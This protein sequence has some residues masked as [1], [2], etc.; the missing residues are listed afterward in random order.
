MLAGQ[1]SQRI[2]FSGHKSDL[3]KAI[4]HFTE[5]V[6]LSS[7]Q[8]IVFALFYLAALLLTRF[9]YYEQPDDIKSSIK[10]FRFLRINFHSVEAFEVPD[11]SGD[12]STHLFGALALG[13]VLTPGEMAQDLDEMVAL[14]PEVITADILTYHRKSAIQDFSRAVANL[15]TEIFRREDTH[16]VADRAIH[17]LREATVLNPDLEIAYALAACLAFRF[18]TTFV[19]KDYEEAI[20][21]FDRIISTCSPGTNLTVMEINVI[22]LILGLLVSRENLSPTPESLEHGIHRLRTLVPYSLGDEDRTRLNLTLN[23]FTHKRF[24]YFGLSGNSGG[25]PPGPYSDLQP[26]T[27]FGRQSESETGSQ[28]QETMYCLNDVATAIM[29]DETTDVGVA[30]EESRKLIPLW[31]SS[32]RWSPSSDLVHM[33][34]GILLNAYRRTERLDYLNEAIITCRDLHKISAAPKLIHFWVGSALHNSLKTR[35]ELLLLPQDLE[36]L[37][38]LSSELAK[39]SSGEVFTRFEISCFWATEARVRVHPSASIAYEMAMSLLQETLVFCPTLQTQHHRLVD[40]SRKGGRFPSDYPSYRIVN[41]EVEE[42]IETL[43]Q[44]RALIW[45]EMRGLRT[46]TDQ[47]R[48]ADPALAD[49]FSIINKTLELVTMSVAHSDNDDD[50]G[51]SE[52]GPG[53][54]ERSIGHLVLKQRRLLEERNSLISHIQSLSG[55]EDF[56]KPPSFDV[57]KSAAAC[58]PVIIINQAGPGFPS[59]IILLLKDSPPSIISTPSSFHDRAIKLETELLSVRKEKGLD[60]NDYDLTL[61]SILS[62][63]YKIVGKPVIERLRELK[64]PK[65]SRVWWCPTGAFCSLPLHAM[66]PIPSDDGKQL[67]FS[68][69]YI[70]SYTP[71]L[72][73]LIESRKRRTSSDASDQ[74]KPS[75]LLVAQPDTLPGAFGEISAIQTT[76]TPVTSLISSMATPKTVINGLRA[77]RFVHFV[78]H[79]LLETGKPFDT[80]LELQ[81]GNL[82]LLAIVRSQLPAA[83]LAFLSACHTAEL[84]EGS[85]ADEVLHLTAAM[86]YCG[87]RSVVGTMWAMAD[88][89]GT[90][91]SKHFYKAIFADKAYQNGV[92][93][94]ERSARALHSAVKKLRKKRGMTLERWVNFVHY[95]A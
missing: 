63:L 2:E 80:S 45:S 72:S 25:T 14:I 15:N 22:R 74:S 87:F 23:A 64:V 7:T 57:L 1:R 29:N 77:H 13:L 46:S 81:K 47:L 43:E 68:D 39:D 52:T 86:Q 56:L 62:D 40:A 24:E 3:D 55:L 67:Y 8:R 26:R 73:A 21:I 27:Y 60:S 9:T 79:G 95:G 6:L 12:V 5:V 84:A 11:I 34:A 20:A 78:C 18:E 49:K 31:Q 53:L 69:L 38:Q 90:D 32:D 70:P 94:H 36:E 82:T 71:T 30:V 28:V 35:L 54:R 58:G 61:A 37:I 42:A 33:F 50:I 10:Y 83:E 65:K 44:G 93:Y 76:K 75:I 19:M 85:V 92:R 89:D 51:R 91:L 59:Y 17:V 4:T 48:A 88:T 16:S 41:G 66:G